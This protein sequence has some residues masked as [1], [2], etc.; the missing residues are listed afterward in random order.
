MVGIAIAMFIAVFG[1]G[2]RYL[3]WEDPDGKVQLALATCFILGVI[4]GYR[5]KS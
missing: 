4:S 1:W 5:A 3:G 2:S